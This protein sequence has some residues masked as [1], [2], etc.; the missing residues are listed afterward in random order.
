MPERRRDL[1]TGIAI[2]GNGCASQGAVEAVRQS[3]I[4]VPM[5]IFSDSSLPA[6]NPMLTTYYLE[7]KISYEELF[8]PPPAWL[9]ESINIHLNTPVVR[10]EPDKKILWDGKGSLWHYE[11]CLVA[12]GG[13]PVVP[14]IEGIREEGVFVVRTAEDAWNIKA[15]ME[16]HRVRSALVIGASMVGIKVVEYLMQEG[17]SCCLADGGAGI[18]PLS[19]HRNCQALIEENLK[20]K[21]L[22]LRFGGRIAGIRRQGEGLEA[23][24]SDCR[25]WG[26][27]GDDKPAEAGQPVMA[28]VIFLC[29]GVR[30]NLSFLPPGKVAVK[31][32]VL[33]DDGMG[34]S[35]KDLYAAGD[36]AAGR[37]VFYG[38]NRVIGL[39]ANARHQGRTAG[40]NMAERILRGS[41]KPG[42][43]D[44]PE[45]GYK[46]TCWGSTAHN[47]TCFCG[48]DFVSMGDPF[49]EG[50]VFERYRRDGGYIRAVWE[51]S[52]LLS[53]N[54]LNCKELAGVFRQLFFRNS[55]YSRDLKGGFLDYGEFSDWLIK[56][57][58]NE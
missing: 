39:L 56:K 16:S 44:G 9:D 3:G 41:Q 5:D 34:T 25:A 47:I 30:P 43:A 7:G 49:A 50:Q 2:I 19:A 20:R 46:E 23:F 38:D 1:N 57:Y 14:S 33:V 6:Y 53:V 37:D 35:C 8:L 17:L 54:L 42:P 31:G 36:C 27:G 15:Y 13:S 32:G 10:L 45:E 48:M 58:M 12:S 51:G 28:D 22:K 24:F 4:K 21:G 40:R 18:F 55:G 29:I 11:C 26:A 52:R